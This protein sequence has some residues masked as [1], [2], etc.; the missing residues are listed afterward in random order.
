MRIILG[1]VI[2]VFASFLFQAAPASA[3]TRIECPLPDATRSITDP[4]PRDWWTTPIRNRLTDTRVQDIAGR[5]ALVCQYGDAG[6]VQTNAPRFQ[7]CVARRGGFDCTRLGP[8]PPGGPGWPGGPGDPRGPDRGA[9]SI[10]QSYMFDLDRG[11]VGSDRG[12]DVWFEAVNPVQLYL[13]PRNGAR[14]ALGDRRDGDSCRRSLSNDRIA[15]TSLMVGYYVCYET[16]EGQRGD[17][18]ITGLTSGS[19]RTLQIE[20][21]NYGDL[22][23]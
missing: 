19:P 8:F 23:R 16:S 9:L 17:F 4:L 11:R 5:P 20:Y 22:R 12:A 18:R 2:A 7:R 1:G 3:Q 13:T 6:S 14:I 15:L 10:P 21:N